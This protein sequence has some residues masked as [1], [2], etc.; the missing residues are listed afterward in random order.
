MPTYADLELA[1]RRRGERSYSVDLRYNAPDSDA[2]QRLI[3]D[4]DGVAEIDV[5]S[6]R[7]LEP[8]WAAYGVAL[9]LAVFTGPVGHAFSGACRNAQ[10]H[11]AILRVRLVIEP[12][13][14]ELHSVHWETMPLLAS[15]QIAFSRYLSSMDWRPVKTRPQGSLKALV[16]VAN[17]ANLDE[18]QPGGQPLAP[19][20]VTGEFERTKTALG[21]IEVQSLLSPGYATLDHVVRRLREGFDILYLVC[22]GALIERQPRLWEPCLYLERADGKV[23]AVSGTELVQLIQDLPQRPRLVVLASCQSAGTGAS[24]AEGS[25]AA[26]LGPQLAQA[27][28]PA[29]LA[30]RGNISI[31]TEAQFMPEFFRELVRDGQIDR[32]V[33]VARR[34]VRARSD[35]WVPVLYMRLRHGRLWYVS[36]FG[37]KGGFDQWAS[38]CRFAARGECVPIVGPDLAESVFG[39]TR[40]IAV[41]LAAANG[42]P[43]SAADGSDPAKVA[44]YIYT[45]ASLEGARQAVRDSLFRRMQ[46]KHQEMFGS[47]DRTMTPP[48][49]L[50]RIAARMAEDPD[51]PY[52]ILASLNAK[53]YVTAGSDPLLELFLGKA[54]K[55]PVELVCNW[56]DERRETRGEPELTSDPTAASPVIY[57]AYGKTKYEDTWVLTEDDFFDYLIQMSKYGLMPGAVNEALTTGS[58]MFLG[59]SLDDWKFRILFRMILAKGGSAQL[60]NYNHVG[61]QLNPDETTLADAERARKY[62]ERYFGETKIDIYWGTAA[63]YLKEL[64]SQMKNARGRDEE[65]AAVSSESW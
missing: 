64:R 55:R 23:A 46:K 40:D 39:S 5:E 4:G 30:M 31:D 61:V 57:Y 49:L 62:L 13:A 32:A 44:Q 22:H 10:S 65:T 1:L 59:F 7:Q 41:E 48:V 27:G 18:Y 43:L 14:P 33:S 11:N 26:A 15:E 2:D 63:D 45:K 17:P 34:T 28:I 58:L 8:D 12:S 29:V 35:F 60:R 3:A 52:G 54:G 50:D 21:A 20:D 25:M 36:G 9:N 51:N 42:F 53:V 16:V 38:I 47:V 24:E 19:V 37:E 6:L 56:R